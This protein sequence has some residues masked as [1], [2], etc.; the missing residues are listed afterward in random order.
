MY[1][2]DHSGIS[3]ICDFVN[4]KNHWYTERVIS[5]SQNTVATHHHCKIMVAIKPT[6]RSCCLIHK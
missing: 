1:T 2:T 6:A 5:K 4:N 3:S